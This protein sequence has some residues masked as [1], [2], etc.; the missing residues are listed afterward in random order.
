[1][2]QTFNNGRVHSPAHRNGSADMKRDFGAL[3]A[4]PETTKELKGVGLGVISAL[5]P[6]LV[7]CSF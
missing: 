7:V 6:L 5:A 2:G 1:M 3:S 4:Q